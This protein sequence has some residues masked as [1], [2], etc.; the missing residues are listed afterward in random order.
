MTTEDLT[1]L[2]K[3][4]L[5]GE[6]G[7][8]NAIKLFKSI[9]TR[10]IVQWTQSRHNHHQ[11]AEQQQVLDQLLRGAPFKIIMN[12]EYVGHQINY[13]KSNWPNVQVIS[14]KEFARRQCDIHQYFKKQQK[15]NNDY[16]IIQ[17]WQWAGQSVDREDRKAKGH[18]V[19]SNTTTYWHAR[20]MVG[21]SINGVVVIWYGSDCNNEQPGMFFNIFVYKGCSL[22]VYIFD[23]TSMCNKTDFFVSIYRIRR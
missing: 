13:I 4:A 23:C 16:I 17:L 6:G 11:I 15:Q 21:L 14:W 8:D 9:S 19:T 2:V 20:T 12:V 5:C 1:S 18:M 3:A 22:C 7:S 10:R